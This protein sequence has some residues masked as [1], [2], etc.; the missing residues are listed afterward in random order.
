MKALALYWFLVGVGYVTVNQDQSQRGTALLKELSAKYK[1]ASM[2]ITLL[3][4]TW[5]YHMNAS[6]SRQYKKVRA[7]IPFLNLILPYYGAYSV[8]NLL[9][10]LTA[11]PF[12]TLD[13]V[14]YSANKS[15]FETHLKALLLTNSL[16]QGEKD[17]LNTKWQAEWFLLRQRWAAINSTVV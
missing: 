12:T 8:M 9:G 4:E 14:L 17:Y 15:A 10:D 1:F 6:N 11:K 2:T 7:L 16:T 13:T 3:E 5:V